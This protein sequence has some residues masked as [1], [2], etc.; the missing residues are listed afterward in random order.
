MTHTRRQ[1][2]GSKESGVA[3]EADEQERYR[4]SECTSLSKTGKVTEDG[5]QKRNH[6]MP[7]L[8]GTWQ[9]ISSYFYVVPTS[10]LQ[11]DH[12]LDCHLHTTLISASTPL[13]TLCLPLHQK[14]TPKGKSSGKN[15]REPKARK[16][17]YKQYCCSFTF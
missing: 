11:T 17:V 16:Q 6:R 14:A 7:G 4:T 10:F 2:K 13:P 15:S 5:E 9:I 12:V 3:E 1:E 8:E